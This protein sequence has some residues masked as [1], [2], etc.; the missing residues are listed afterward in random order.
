MLYVINDLEDEFSIIKA[1]SKAHDEQEINAILMS[2]E[3]LLVS[4]GND[5]TIK[6][7]DLDD[8]QTYKGRS[9]KVLKLESEITALAMSPKGLLLSA[10][11]NREIK[12]TNLS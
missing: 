12:V 9:V 10:S 4:A 11:Y 2:G 8:K 6:I 5:K 3:N 7:W 1:I